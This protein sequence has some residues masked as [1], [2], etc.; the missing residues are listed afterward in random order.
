MLSFGVLA[1]AGFAAGREA[2]FGAC[3]GARFGAL[4]RFAAGA[5]RRAVAPPDFFFAAAR[6]A[7]GFLGADFFFVAFFATGLR[8]L[9]RF[10]LTFFAVRFFETLFFATAFFVEPRFAL[11]LLAFF[12]FAGGL[13][14]TDRFAEVGR[15]AVAFFP[16]RDFFFEVLL[17]PAELFRDAFFRVAIRT[18]F[19][20]CAR[21][22]ETREHQFPCVSYLY[23]L[24]RARDCTRGHCSL[25]KDLRFL[26]TSIVF[27]SGSR[28]AP[29]ELRAHC[30]V[31]LR[32]V[33]LRA[34]RS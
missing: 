26:L 24:L 21:D 16:E 17:L 22:A 31:P 20:S 33:P 13:R 5:E 19:S 4:L 1:A 9:D 34:L 14:E 8:A 6:F 25:K 28:S 18:P 29:P 32:R 30:R 23:E 11:L 10:A 12:F 27:N 15:R 2:R 7:T 3:F